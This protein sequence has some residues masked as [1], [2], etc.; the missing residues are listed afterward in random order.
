MMEIEG[1]LVGSR[2]WS[3]EFEGGEF[4]VFFYVFYC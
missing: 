3:S 4:I 1:V 2:K